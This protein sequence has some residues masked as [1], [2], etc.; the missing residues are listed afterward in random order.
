MGAF[1]DRN[2]AG[3]SLNRANENLYFPELTPAQAA[4]K[5]CPRH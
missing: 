1:V 5:G 2:F 4:L 3:S